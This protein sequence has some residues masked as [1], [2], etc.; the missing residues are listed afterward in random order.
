MHYTFHIYSEWPLD[1]VNRQGIHY[2]TRQI[3]YKALAYYIPDIGVANY[4]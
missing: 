1:T 4:I 3:H 2:E